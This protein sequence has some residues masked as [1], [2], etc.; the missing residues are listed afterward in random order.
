MCPAH[1]P[2]VTGGP[3]GKPLPRAKGERD[4]GG[5]FAQRWIEY[6]LQR[7]L[8]SPPG[9]VRSKPRNTARG[10]PGS[11]PAPAANISR[12]PSTS[13]T[14]PWGSAI[15]GIPRA[16]AHAGAKC[17]PS[18][19]LR[20]AGA[21]GNDRGCLTIE[22]MTVCRPATSS[23]ASC[24]T[25]HPPRRACAARHPL[26]AHAGRGKETRCAGNVGWEPGNG[27]GRSLASGRNPVRGLPA[28]S[29]SSS[30]SP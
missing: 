3:R 26:P 20:G 2:C 4:H 1:Q 6:G 10:M 22:L 23:A 29:R 27:V 15:P 8:V 16:P 7:S 28:S 14:R 21:R 11:L 30:G 25:P 24:G 12:V 9:F 5:I 13:H 19:M 18:M 17:D